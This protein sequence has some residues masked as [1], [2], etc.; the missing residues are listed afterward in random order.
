MS[1]VSDVGSSGSI[2]PQEL[3]KQVTDPNENTAVNFFYDQYADQV[4]AIVKE[5]HL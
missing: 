4:A 2:L 5:E 3:V 1:G